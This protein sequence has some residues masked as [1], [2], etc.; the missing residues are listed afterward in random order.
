MKLNVKGCGAAGAAHHD[1]GRSLPRP[2]PLR[3]YVALELIPRDVQCVMENAKDVDIAVVLD[4]VRNS[5]V[6]VEKYPDV[7]RR[8]GVSRSRQRKAPE[9]LRPFVDAL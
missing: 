2:A 9:I 5:V 4:E 3:G 6:P 1:T 7:P 8:R